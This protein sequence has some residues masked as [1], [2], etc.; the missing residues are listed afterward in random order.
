MLWVKAFHVIF[1]VAWY[2]GLLYLPRLFVYHAQT[3]DTLGDERFRVMERRLFGI[4]TVGG[5]GALAFGLWLVAEYAWTAYASS[6][7]FRVKLAL[8]AGL[9]LYHVWC[10]T[11]RF[12]FRGGAQPARAS[13]LPNDE[14]GAGGDPDRSD[15]T[16]GCQAGDGCA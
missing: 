7:W 5:V 10:G 11:P 14:R 4:M 6:G 15:D 13:L 16:R 2:A 8:V 12:R 1:V 3:E 9:V